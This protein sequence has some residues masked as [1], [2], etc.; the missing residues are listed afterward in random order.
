MKLFPRR[1]V[2]LGLLSGLMAAA[3]STPAAAQSWP[4]KPIRL[5]VPFASGGGTDFFARTVAPGMASALGQPVIIENKPGGSTVIAAAEAK[6]AAPDGYTVFLG[7]MTTFAV[8]PALMKS[9]SYD[10]QKDFAPVTLTARYVF[11][12][13]AHPS[14]P[15]NSV[16]EVIALAGQKPGELAYG[17]SG[18]GTLPH[19]GMALLEQKTGVR[20]VHVPYKGG[21]PAMQD[22]MAGSI[23]L[24]LL[25]LPSAQANLK[26]GRFKVLGAATTKRFAGLPD[27]P[28]LAEVAVPGYEASSWQGLSVPTGTP[29]ELIEKIRSAYIQAIADPAVHKKLT[30][31]GLE[32]LTSTPSEMAEHIKAESTKWAEVIRVGKISID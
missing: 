1:R 25:D 13:A 18:A 14:V 7:D 23:P 24:L 12:L 15:V 27:V 19:L 17:S 22:L 2:F 28:T 30:E 16:K 32:L 20:M 3:L 11:I 21:A 4:K 26:S 5:I 9:L 31:A 10:P 29:K 8:N 6:R